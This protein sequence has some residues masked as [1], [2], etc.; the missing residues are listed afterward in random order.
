MRRA[1][2]LL[3]CFVAGF[4]LP[5]AV[6]AQA[7]VLEGIA[8]WSTVRYG[9]RAVTTIAPAPGRPGLP[10][11]HVRPD[12]IGGIT[13]TVAADAS[14]ARWSKALGVPYTSGVNGATQVLGS[15]VARTAT[16][17]AVLEAAVAATKLT[18]PA[19][20]VILGAGIFAS[21]FNYD[22]DNARLMT[23]LS[24]EV[25]Q[26]GSAAP[27]TVYRYASCNGAGD[28][29]PWETSSSA[30]WESCLDMYQPAPLVCTQY[31]QYLYQLT[32]ARK[33]EG[34]TPALEVAQY[35]CDYPGASPAPTGYTTWVLV[36]TGPY[37]E[38]GCPSGA[39]LQ[40]GVCVFP[41]TE[42]CPDGYQ[43]ATDFFY[44]G[45]ECRPMPGTT[46]TQYVAPDAMVSAAFDHE[47]GTDGAKLEQLLN[48]L[49][50]D[51][52]GIE[53]ALDNP[54]ASGP[55][56]LSPNT[57]IDPTTNP[58]G[59]REQIGTPNVTYVG[60]TVNIT[61]NIVNNY[62][63]EENNLIGSETVDPPDDNVPPV[64][65]GSLPEVPD[66]YEQKYPDGFAG[67]WDAH[68]ASLAGSAFV[69]LIGALAPD[70][71]DGG[72]CPEFELP[73]PLMGL[74]MSGNF[75]PPCWLWPILRVVVVITALFAAR[76]II[77]GG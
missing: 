8:S 5:F 53:A 38:V 55:A 7:G 26:G 71:G 11:T 1:I 44:P 24:P 65:D 72:S 43:Y 40:G 28:P 25:T 27:D 60:N 42:G 29:G 37:T 49:P 34:Q 70:W 58:A 6:Y 9:G 16:K 74:V 4:L 18:N 50:G 15:T 12:A 54:A 17:T 19:G 69:G 57:R 56:S 68:K 76:R 48:D 51:G 41:E 13:R 33:P 62:Y 2:F 75:A 3:L 67:V 21:Y 36:P 32:G 77:F 10:T 59:H 73:S 22:T 20:W 63:D 39:T 47:V 45:F 61:E 35:Y 46:P 66:F 30:A 23:Y 14:Y 52:P 64:I 31:Y